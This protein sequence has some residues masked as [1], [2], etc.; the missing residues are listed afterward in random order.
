MKKQWI[1]VIVLFAV[2]VVWLYLTADCVVNRA[3][4]GIPIDWA[5]IKDCSY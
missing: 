1:I 3:S 5:N 4:F 2:I